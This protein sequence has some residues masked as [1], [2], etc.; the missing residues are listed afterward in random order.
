MAANGANT[1]DYL[2]FNGNSW[3]ASPLDINETQWINSGN[4]IYY[5]DGRV[6][7]NTPSPLARL[8]VNSLST[9]DAFRVQVN[10]TS[11]LWV[12]QDG[13]TNDLGD[14]NLSNDAK[15]SSTKNGSVKYMVKFAVLRLMLLQY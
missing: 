13:S 1:N 7:V 4:N 15:Q 11:K 10:G 14:L 5:P 3:A 8:H 9:E 12:K 2:K 6:G